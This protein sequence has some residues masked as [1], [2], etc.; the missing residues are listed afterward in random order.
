MESGIRRSI[1]STS[2]FA[3]I[4]NVGITEDMIVRNPALGVK[5]PAISR[6]E[7]FFLTEEQVAALVS[8]APEANRPLLLFLPFTGARIGEATALRVPNLNLVGRTVRFT[9]NASEVRGKRVI[10]E[11]KSK[12][13]R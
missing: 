5:T 6:R 13:V 7:P 2:F 1:T 10:G 8:A 12:R 9:E 11:T 4:L 3:P